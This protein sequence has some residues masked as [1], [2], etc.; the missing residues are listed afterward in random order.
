MSVDATAGLEG[1]ELARREA[2]LAASRQAAAVTG[3]AWAPGGGLVA[4]CTRGALHFVPPPKAASAAATRS[5]QA[6]AGGGAAWALCAGGGLCW[7][8]G[9]DGVVRGWRW[10]ALLEGMVDAALAAEIPVPQAPGRRGA[11]GERPVVNALEWDPSTGALLAGCGDGACHVLDAEACCSKAKIG[12]HEGAVLALSARGT[13]RQAVTA[14]EDGSARVWDV[15]SG[16]NVAGVDPLHARALQPS[17][18]ARGPFAGCCAVDAGEH[19][20]AVGSGAGCIALWSFAAGAPVLRIA[21]SAAPQALEFS[22]DSL[23]GVGAEP[24]LNRWAFASGRLLNRTACAPLSGYALALHPTS[25]VAAVGGGPHATLEL[26]SPLG[27]SLSMR[28]L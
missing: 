13:H 27:S 21:T 6:E 12:A 8:G 24:Y 22:G 16:A 23:S 18:D 11:L 9:D 26:L 4:T 5:V 2:S 19:W 3:L 10:D 28:R 25:G 14:S 7:V 1:R 15:R 17:Q 20:L